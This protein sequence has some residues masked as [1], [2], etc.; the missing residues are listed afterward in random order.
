MFCRKNVNKIKMQ[1]IVSP[2]IP[3]N[4]T[5]I[6][7]N[8]FHYSFVKT[9]P[10]LKMLKCYSEHIFASQGLWSALLI[11]TLGIIRRICKKSSVRHDFDSI[12]KFVRLAATL[13][14]QKVCTRR[15]FLL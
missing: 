15:H 5:L 3:R 2:A 8:I 9:D 4:W 11:F 14:V 13:F 6:K 7:K 12:K 10:Q 1:K